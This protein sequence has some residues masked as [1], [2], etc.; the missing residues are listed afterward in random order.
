MQAPFLT[1]PCLPP[2]GVCAKYGGC[3]RGPRNARPRRA[4]RPMI[5]KF[6]PDRSPLPGAALPDCL[7]RPNPSWS[8]TTMKL[9]YLLLA[10]LLCTQ[11]RAAPVPRGTSDWPAWRGSQRTGISLETGLL[12]EWPEGGPKLAWQTSGMGVGF[13]TPAVAGGRVYLMGNRDGQELVL[14]LSARDQGK[15]LWSAILG[16]VRHEG[17]PQGRDAPAP[18]HRLLLGRGARK[19]EG[20]GRQEIPRVG[21]D[22]DRLG[23][24]RGIRGDGTSPQPR[25]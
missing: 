8:V 21:H 5:E 18:Q 23:A 2:V 13:S 3:R 25:S 12:R 14:A 22:E 6:L 16:P 10:L 24:P 1:S 19:R 9:S 17:G 4:Y 11:I 7:P 15:E 20:Q